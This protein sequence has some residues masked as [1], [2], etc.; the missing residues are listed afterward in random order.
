[1]PSEEGGRSFIIKKSQHVNPKKKKNQKKKKKPRTGKE[2]DFN[3][4]SWGKKKR[5]IGQGKPTGL[6]KS[7]LWGKIN[8]A[9]EDTLELSKAIYE[10][11]ISPYH[12]EKRDC[13][14]ISR[15]G[16]DARGMME[17][18]SVLRGISRPE[19]RVLRKGVS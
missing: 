8:E 4:R 9:G 19:G 5:D 16:A 2:N 12:Q 3:N 18:L 14:R 10:K 6:R 7:L 15:K 13:R 11:V 17:K 1:M